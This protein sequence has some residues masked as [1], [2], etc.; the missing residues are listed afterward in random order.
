MDTIFAAATATVKS[1]VA[2]IRLSGPK[3]YDA[4]ETLT[5]KGP[6]PP[7]VAA[8][9][10][11]YS[12]GTGELID[13]ALVLRFESPHSFT[14]ED[15][16]ELHVHGSRAVIAE[17]LKEL[18]SL[19]CLRL[20]EAGEFSRRAFENGRMDLTEAE[21]LADL[22]DAE[23]KVQAK[24]ALRQM[25][26]M[27]GRLYESWREQLIDILARLEAYI[28]FPDEDIPDNI[29][30]DVKERITALNMEILKHLD[31][32]NRGE[33]LRN[34][35]CAVIVGAPNTGKSS[36][37]NFLA[38]RDIAIVSEHAGTTRDM[39]EVHLDLDGYPVT[40][41]DTA[42]LR[43]T[44]QEIEGEG[45]RRA[46]ERAKH[47][48]LK[49]ALFDAN[50]CPDLDAATLDL[51]DDNTLILINKIDMVAT[52]NVGEINRKTPYLLSVTQ[53]TG[54]DAFIEALKGRV[55]DSLAL[56]EHPMITQQRHRNLLEETAQALHRFNFDNELELGAEELRLAARSLGRITG[57]IDVED[58]LDALF[59]NFCIGK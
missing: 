15:V 21:G 6:P 37:L 25:Q 22:I 43:S 54:V 44:Q 56:S 49:I 26:G 23:T 48:D 50:A 57:R 31:D 20:A 30:E 24:Q 7:R 51:I 28:D 39:I 40:I 9:R 11:L 4:L 2:I 16:V 27:L 29:I 34:G 14:G 47:A 59:S 17:L 38:K 58:I 32:N 53:N 41:V 1:G 52:P 46:L 5:H 42:G 18:S 35:I 36:L 19:P 12:P 13:E 55:R 45:I 33:K 8:I 10:K 3:A